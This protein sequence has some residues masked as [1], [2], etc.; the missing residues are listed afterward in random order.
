[1]GGGSWVVQEGFLLCKRD[2]S[3]SPRSEGGKPP[4]WKPTAS[5]KSLKELYVVLTMNRKLEFFDGSDAETRNKV[6]SAYL[7]GFGGWDGDGL[8]KVDS[9]GLELKVERNA[10]SRMHLAAFNRVDLEKWCRGFMAVLDPHSA[11]GE[12]VR[13]ERRRVKKEEK[14]LQQ[15]RE[16]QIRKWKEK[17]ARMIKEE[18]DRLLA[19]EEEINNMTPL[20]RIDDIG[21]L[22]DDTARML[23][24]RKQRLQRRQAPTMGRVNK[25]AY[26]RRLDEAAG[27]KTENVQ[28][29]HTKMVE[30]K[31]KVRVELPPP[32]QFF[33]VGGVVHNDAPVRLGSSG[34]DISDS[35]SMSSR[36]SSVS[37]VTGSRHDGGMGNLPPPPPPPRWSSSSRISITSRASMG[38]PPPP[39]PPPLFDHESFN[40]GEPRFSRSSSSL[41]SASFDSLAFDR[42]EDPMAS[43]ASFSQNSRR[44]SSADKGKQHIQDNLAAILG[45]GR[46]KSASRASRTSRRD[47]FGSTMSSITTAS[48][49]VPERKAKVNANRSNGSNSPPAPEPSMANAFAASLAA[50]RRNRA[51]T[52]EEMS[53]ASSALSPVAASGKVRNRK[54]DSQLSAEGKEILKKA[55]AQDV[56]SKPKTK[57]NSGRRGLFDDSS[58]EEDDD[59]DAGLFG[60]GARKSKA[61]NGTSR[62]STSMR[63]SDLSVD[64]RPTPGKK[65]APA[66]SVSSEEV[67]S[68]SDSDNETSFFA[69]PRKTEPTSP[70]NVRTNNVGAGGA[71]PSVVVLLTTS[72][73]RTEGRKSVGVFTFTLQF[74]NMEHTFSFT[75]SEL[76]EIHTRLT[77]AFPGTTLPKFPSKH[78]LRNN[79]KPENMEKRAQEFRL[80][81]QQLVAL[82]GVLSSERFQFEYHIDGAFARAL[83]NGQKPNESATNGAQSNGRP[84]RS[85]VAPQ[86]RKEPTAL[87]AP[88]RSDSPPPR[89][90]K[91]KASKGLFGLDSD[92]ESDSDTSVDTPKPM[93]RQRRE[94]AASSTQRRK[95]RTSDFSSS[96][97]SSV[98]EDT[99]RGKKSRSRS[100][101]SSRASSRAS[102]AAP[103]PP[104]EPPKPVAVTGLPP[105][106][107]NRFAGGRGDLLAAIR[108]GAQLKKAT[109][110][111]SA[112][113]SSSGGA[114]AAAKPPPPPA[115][116]QPGSIN[117][118]ITNAMAMRRIHVE[119]EETKSNADS[120]SDD[121]WD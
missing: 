21:S 76:E 46:P 101:L 3:A 38:I 58:S 2:G 106:R 42:D 113:D 11:A 39:P 20:E 70:K 10:K 77:P 1:M 34:S 79:T 66:P 53:V 64:A 7:Q 4:N 59:S 80:Y 67:S 5:S 90:A 50:I 96:V 86:P 14:R 31:A 95:P 37:S 84:P 91:P 51:D 97:I 9:Y 88:S 89:A 40:D 75:Y 99:G 120:D 73:L 94:S 115:L 62:A 15:E 19:R 30:Q 108:Q 49:A 26:R 13:R 44:V 68:D 17:K 22:D 72:A 103:P 12:E 8:L 27:G 87:S 100:R 28:P 55:M 65:A 92:P 45:G 16:E 83:A 69:Q 119:Y 74:G 98:A 52:V 107:P 61:A 32:G 85:P 18:Q 78:R 36:L 54:R 105:G 104:V 33:E 63:S 114:L 6:D 35:S 109:S 47:S 25:A 111:D 81:L 116:S 121:D 118:A 48:Y 60:V 117:E 29:L 57:A 110:G 93:T 24:K 82:P 56:P 41:R 23:E 112:G 102:F 43:R 71:G